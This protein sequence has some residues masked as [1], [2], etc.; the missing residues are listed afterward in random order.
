MYQSWKEASCRR[1]S[2]DPGSTVEI[3]KTNYLASRPLLRAY[4]YYNYYD[5][6]SEHESD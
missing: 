1:R 5:K 4:S 6:R 2:R 3:R